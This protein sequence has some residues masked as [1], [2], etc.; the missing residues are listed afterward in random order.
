MPAERVNMRRV[1]EML[2]YRFEQGLGYKAISLRVGAVPSTV[3]ETLKRVA[4]AGLEW[5]LPEDMSD[6]ALEAALYREPGNKTGYRWCP[7]PDWPWLHREMQRKHVTLQILW[8]EYIA[9]HPDGYRYSRFCDLY[10]AWALK[11]PVTMRQ[12]HTP[13]D[14]L[15]T[16]E[17]GFVKLDQVLGLAPRAVQRIID[18]FSAA[19]AQRGDDKANIETESAC[20]DASGDAALVLSPAFCRIFGL[21]I[22]TQLAAATDRA[23][24]GA[25]V[26]F[27]HDDGI[28]MKRG[29]ARE[30]E[31]IVDAILFAPL[32]RLGAAI[33]AVAPQSDVG[34]GP[35]APD[36]P[37]EP[38]DMAGDFGARRRL[39]G[40]Q[41]HRNRPAS[42]GV[43]DVDRQKASLAMVAVPK[44]KLL[45]TVNDVDRVVDVECDGGRRCGI[46]R[47]VD[48]DQ[49]ACQAEDLARGR[50]IL[51]ARHCRL[52][53]ETDRPIRQLAESE[54]FDKLR[55]ALKPGSWRSVSRSSASS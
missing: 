9:A 19:V 4:A 41:Q 23:I 1:R 46:A 38:P 32:H 55:R 24:G 40:A 29:I 11:L 5:P 13:G 33:V 31:D 27:R 35:M 28:R 25:T 37:D 54:P 10:R 2:R 45:H 52:A 22:S 15:F 34:L 44:G 21:R 39:A 3:R 30:P 50:R 17:L 48:I 51:P 53:G 47:T 6:G 42:F 7:E 43:V 18:I 49:R 36:A 12:N 14:K 26:G 8:D 16:L 20:L